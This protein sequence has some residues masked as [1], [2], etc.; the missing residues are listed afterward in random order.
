MEVEEKMKVMIK[1]A[2]ADCLKEAKKAFA[3]FSE[4]TIREKELWDLFSKD[5][6]EPDAN[7]GLWLESKWTLCFSFL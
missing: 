5:S 6:L 3:Q 7:W 4:K 2:Q 1:R